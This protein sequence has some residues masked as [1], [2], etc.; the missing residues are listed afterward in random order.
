VPIHTRRPN[1]YRPDVADSVQ[2]FSR[3]LDPVDR[4]YATNVDLQATA[5]YC[6]SLLFKI[7]LMLC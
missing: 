4:H 7:H 6:S 1:R 3:S 5:R 2:C